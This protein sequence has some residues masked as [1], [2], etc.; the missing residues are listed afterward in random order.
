MDKQQFCRRRLALWILQKDSRTKH[1]NA[2]VEKGRLEQS[3]VKTISQKY[4]RVQ[5]R[6]SLLRSHG[7]QS[8]VKCGTQATFIAIGTP[9]SFC[10]KIIAVFSEPFSFLL[11]PY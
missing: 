9:V 10:S 6:A 7:Q 8:F 2:E 1:Q 5:D 3:V 4:L 11:I